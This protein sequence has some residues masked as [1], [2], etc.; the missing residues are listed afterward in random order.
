MKQF[1][2]SLLL[3]LLYSAAINLLIYLVALPLFKKLRRAIYL[4][5][6]PEKVEYLRR[7]SDPDFRDAIREVNREFPKIKGLPKPKVRK[8]VLLLPLILL[9]GMTGFWNPFSHVHLQWFSGAM[10]YVD[11][12]GGVDSNV[13]TDSGHPW[14]H[15]PGD[16]NGV[17]APESTT[18]LTAGD[19]VIFKGGITYSGRVDCTWSGSSGSPITYISG[20]IVSWGSGRAIIDGTGVTLDTNHHGLFSIAGTISYLTWQGFQFNN[21]PAN[22][23][24]GVGYSGG[25]GFYS[26]ASSGGFVLNNLYVNGGQ[27]NGISCQGPLAAQI[28]GLTI[29][30]CILANNGVHGIL[31][32][33]G[34]T[35]ILIQ[36]NTIHNAGQVVANTGDGIYMG[37]NGS[38]AFATNVDII[39]NTI[40]DCAVKGFMLLTGQGITV[41]K[42]YCYT[43]AAQSFGIGVAT[44]YFGAAGTTSNVTIRNN[45]VAL[46][47]VIEGCVRIQCTEN[48]GDLI[49]GVYIYNNT[50]Y[51]TGAYYNVWLKEGT[52]TQ[53]SAVSNVVIKNNIMI[54]TNGGSFPQC[55]YTY[56][57]KVTSGFDCQNNHYWWKGGLYPASANV[58]QGTNQ[59]WAQWQ[60]LGFDTFTHTQNVDPKLIA[61]GGPF[62]QYAP[63]VNSPVINAGLD[64]SSTGFSNDINGVSRPQGSNWDIGA[65][66]FIISGG[67]PGGLFGL[68]VQDGLKNW[69]PGSFNLP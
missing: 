42:N 47:G 30:N 53:A 18:N 64:L 43:T 68:N 8:Q 23:I 60:A 66:E 22:T 49:N 40:Y 69:T 51:Q 65:Y 16:A 38:T 46:N 31:I 56:S 39:S 11:Y 1:F 6:H 13:G 5:R 25:V 29:T 52:S 2:R 37:G 32:T 21:V 10:Y 27:E 28:S 33:N 14:K 41:E 36:G 59:S 61:S 19:T 63:L 67:P 15:S 4:R 3:S 9:V 34:W 48:T 50:M 54:E 45:V 20:D 44:E 24:N 57:S 7:L 12:V 35:N 62:V 58:W 17:T 26:G 55:V